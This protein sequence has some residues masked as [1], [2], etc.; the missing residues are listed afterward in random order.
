MG[1]PIFEVRLNLLTPTMYVASQLRPQT[2]PGFQR[3]LRHENGHIS[4]WFDMMA[5][6]T[7]PIAC[8]LNFDVNMLFSRLRNRPPIAGEMN[9]TIRTAINQ[10]LSLA[11]SDADVAAD[12]WDIED[13]PRLHAD[14]LALSVRI[15]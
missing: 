5:R 3:V 4:S 15:P 10:V 11:R 14:L 8:R 13:L 12:R 6:A 2:S 7:N 9:N 1:G